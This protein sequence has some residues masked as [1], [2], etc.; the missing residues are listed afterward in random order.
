MVPPQ[1]NTDAIPTTK[2]V[3]RKILRKANIIREKKKL[4][5]FNMGIN[6]AVWGIL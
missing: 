4:V 2:I 3:F 1:P 6:L 5:C